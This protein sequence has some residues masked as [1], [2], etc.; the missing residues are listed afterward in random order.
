MIY[1]YQ[2]KS[3]LFI[4]FS[5]IKLPLKINTFKNTPSL[6]YFF[7]KRHIKK[8]KD[9]NKIKTSL[10]KRNYNKISFL[11][12]FNPSF[13]QNKLRLVN[14]QKILYLSYNRLN[15]TFEELYRI[16]YKCVK[17][18]FIQKPHKFRKKNCSSKN[19]AKFI[20][21][22]YFSMILFSLI[23]NLKS[24]FASP[25]IK[26]IVNYTVMVIDYLDLM[27]FGA[28]CS[29]R[30]ISHSQT[31]RTHNICTLFISLYTRSPCVLQLRETSSDVF[32]TK[33]KI[34]ELIIYS[35]QFVPLLSLVFTSSLL[36]L[37]NSLLNKLYHLLKTSVKFAFINPTVTLESLRLH[38]V[39][40]FFFKYS[41]KLKKMNSE[42]FHISKFKRNSTNFKTNLETA[43]VVKIE[44]T[45]VDSTFTIKNTKVCFSLR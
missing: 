31:R 19:K 24:Q 20:N 9:D 11:Y 33:T 22:N 32:H 39:T 40:I 35:E 23:S 1:D 28:L 14:T 42:S 27:Y 45:I 34:I 30:S 5:Q 8:K 29:G 3:I 37:C 10:S 15:L 44:S 2:Q 16:K 6:M 43:T 13:F 25:F 17:T 26:N 18:R 38:L 41:C 4:S 12:E 21:I 7:R 36:F